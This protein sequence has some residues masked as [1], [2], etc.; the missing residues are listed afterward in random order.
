MP[1]IDWRKHIFNVSEAIGYLSSLIWKQPQLAVFFAYFPAEERPDSQ[2]ILFIR[3][4]PKYMREVVVAEL[5]RDNIKS[6]SS[7][8]STVK[9]IPG[10]HKAYV[11]LSGGIR[12]VDEDDMDNFYLMYVWF[13][14]EGHR[15]QVPVRVI[16]NKE[17]SA[18]EF[19]NSP[20]HDEDR[21]LLCRLNFGLSPL[22]IDSKALIKTG[23]QPGAMF[24][25]K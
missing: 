8:D 18:V 20:K 17:L 24:S 1:I 25:P 6:P 23:K 22:K 5:E 13:E 14:S 11:S 3:C 12:A 2:D 16:S 4:Y 10:H 15:Q 21:H 9:M 19:Y 7:S